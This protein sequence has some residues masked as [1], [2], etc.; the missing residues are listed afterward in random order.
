MGV[1][2]LDHIQIAMPKGQE[3]K[4]RAFYQDILGVLEV[5]KPVELSGHGGAWFENGNLKIHL[6]VE[7][8]FR[9]AR[10]AYP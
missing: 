4:A 3:H 5:S 2:A 6:G 8:D 10:K 9:P 7:E 1:V